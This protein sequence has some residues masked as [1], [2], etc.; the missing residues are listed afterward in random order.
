MS[1]IACC[2]DLMQ[3]A[4]QYLVNELHTKCG[5]SWLPHFIVIIVVHIAEPILVVS[6]RS[7][8]G[9]SSAHIQLMN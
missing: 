1:A 2:T 3:H 9:K 8:L 4:C 7:R 6:S 5:V